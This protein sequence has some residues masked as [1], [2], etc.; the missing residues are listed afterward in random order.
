MPVDAD[1][2]SLIDKIRLVVPTVGTVSARELRAI[3]NA[4]IAAAPPGPAV[5]RVEDTR[6]PGPAGG[7]PIRT[8]WPTGRPLAVIAYFHGG[9]WTIGSID[10][11]DAGVRRMA[12]ATGCVIVSVE[13]RLAPE[14]PF[15]AA[16][17]DALQAVRWVAGNP[18]HFAPIKLPLVVSGDSAGANLAAVVAQL[19]RDNGG[20]DIAAQVLIYPSTEGDID[21]DFMNRFPSPYLTREEIAWFYDA[22]IPNRAERL[23]PRFA[24]LQGRLRGLPPAFVLTAENDLLAEEGELYATAMQEAGVDARVTEYAGTV[25][26]FIMMHPSLQSHS[27][28]A[29]EDIAQFLRQTLATSCAAV[30]SA[31]R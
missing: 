26:G 27:T 23:D 15:P 18:E 6:I 16:V 25:H 5:E 13:Y 17:E 14:F 12:L 22:Y 29:I 20:P 10:S 28:R 1:V 31:V 11:S 30:D 3:Q 9:G 8:Y 24:P 21:S 4:L 19:A 7:I 2:Q